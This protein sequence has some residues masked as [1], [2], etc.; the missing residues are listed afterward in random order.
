MLSNAVD[1]YLV[2]KVNQGFNFQ[3]YLRVSAKNGHDATLD[4][5]AKV[6]SRSS[7]FYLN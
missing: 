3:P 2:E 5:A 7:S 4:F 6:H 1:P